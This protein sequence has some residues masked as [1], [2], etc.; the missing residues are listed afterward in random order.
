MVTG[1]TADHSV[2]PFYAQVQLFDPGVADAIPDWTAESLEQGV[3]AGPSGLAILTRGDFKRGAE[4]LSR[5]RLRVWVGSSDL[6]PFSPLV[7]EGELQVG[8]DCVV[9]GSVVGNDLHTV[10]VPTGVHRVRVHAERRALRKSLMWSWRP[11]GP[12]ADAS[13]VPSVY[14]QGALWAA[15]RVGSA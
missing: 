3:A 14:A 8:G 7:Y 11:C 12:A 15:R 1:P 13:W 10:A 4:D 9:I 2:V 6:G 5:V